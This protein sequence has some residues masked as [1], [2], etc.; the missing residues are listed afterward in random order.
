MKEI[1]KK[2]IIAALFICTWGLPGVHAQTSVNAGGG[3]TIDTGGSLSFSV[4]QLFFKTVSETTGTISEGV[5][6]PFEIFGTNEVPLNYLLSNT[7]IL[8]GDQQCYNAQQTIAVAG[9]E[10]PVYVQA[11]GNA[12]FIAGQTIRFLPGFHAEPGSYVDAHITTDGTFCDGFVPESIVAVPTVAE[13]SIEIGTNNE[14]QQNPFDEKRV[15]LYPNP[16]NGRFTLET[17]N[18]G[19]QKQIVV[20]NMAGSVI[21]REKTYNNEPFLIDLP[22]GISG[23]YN[24]R[25]SDGKTAKGVKMIVR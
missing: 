24:L 6:H 23:I 14:V 22:V 21:Y 7:D 12:R 11:G 5:Q 17:K 1:R 13:K 25:V 20:Y 4:G 9:D 18:F 3:N 15:K 19:E 8:S 10:G 2:W 16:N